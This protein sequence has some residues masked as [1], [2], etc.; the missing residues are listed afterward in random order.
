MPL[1]AIRTKVRPKDVVL[2]VTSIAAVVAD[3][4]EMAS[5]PPV[6]AAATVLLVILQTIQEIESNKESCHRLARRAARLLLDLKHRMEGRWDTAPKALV[7]N[8]L[9]FEKVLESIRDF[10]QD[11][12]KVKW[13]GRLLQKSAI[14]ESLNRYYEMLDEAEKSFQI[15]SLVE[16]HYAVGLLQERNPE[17]K[18]LTAKADEKEA[19]SDPPP[20]YEVVTDPASDSPA[21]LDVLE[22]KMQLVKIDDNGAGQIVSMTSTEVI[23]ADE[24]Q[25]LEDEIARLDNFGFKRL[26]QSEVRLKS[27]MKGTG[28]S[29]F[30]SG[31]SVADISGQRS[32]IKRYESSEEEDGKIVAKKRWLHDVK[33]L[34][35]LFHPNLPQM[36]AFSADNAATPFIVLADVKLRDPNVYLLNFLQN[37][38]IADCVA[39]M[40]RMYRDVSSAILYAQRQLKLNEN[41]TQNFVSEASYS[42]DSDGN[43]MVGL[44]PPKNSNSVTIYAYGLTDSL[45]KNTLNYLPTEDHLV[46]LKGTSDCDKITELREKYTHFRAIALNLLPKGGDSPALVEAL[47]EFLDDEEEEDGCRSLVRLRE[48]KIDAGGHDHSWHEGVHACSVQFDVGDVGYISGANVDLLDKKRF[49]SF[50]KI[51]NVLERTRASTSENSNV[52]LPVASQ[53]PVVREASGMQTQWVNGFFN[54]QDVYPFILPGELEGWPLS[55]NAQEE[56]SIIVRHTARMESV[57]EAWRF[58]I[59]EARSIANN[60]GVKPQDIILITSSV[61]GET[62]TVKHFGYVP[63]QSSGTPY[64]MGMNHPHAHAHN[65]HFG[66]GQHPQFGNPGMHGSSGHFHHSPFPPPVPQLLYL[67][68]SSRSDFKAFWSSNPSA[69]SA[70]ANKREPL[71]RD[72]SEQ[73][74]WPEAYINYIQLSKEDFDDRT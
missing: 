16:I 8:I 19:E 5:F 29:S 39:Q 62:Y 41:E 14:E 67:F 47:E 50:V 73:I 42:L 43:V 59:R 49:N 3:V 7:E 2:A 12:A 57:N 30:W 51:G 20:L 60:A 23:S 68:T 46:S 72:I 17:R 28:S 38:S 70:P 26:H 31:C 18:L 65:H 24:A 13:M 58:L 1:K 64:G 69:A 71:P 55:L 22:E 10:M 15:S 21:T 4:A 63:F 25:A 35:E 32:I 52:Q 6:R 66:F 54:R 53:I 37:R 34:K 44:P 74:G 27:S 9:E 11:L 40:L 36:S 48:L 45:L 61:R 56:I 33:R